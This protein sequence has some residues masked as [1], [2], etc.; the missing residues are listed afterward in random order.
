MNDSTKYTSL[1]AVL[2]VVASALTI[3]K[4]LNAEPLLSANDRSRWATV[5][6]IVERQTYTIDEI[7]QRTGWSTIDKVRFQGHYYSSKP[8]LFPRLVAE[9]AAAVKMAT[10]LSLDDKPRTTSRVVLL[11]VNVLPTIASWVAV[12]WMLPKFARS[13]WAC[14]FTLSVLCFA[15]LN[16]PFLVTLNNHSVAIWSLTLTLACMTWMTVAGPKGRW[17]A[18]G[19]GGLFA[20]WTCCNELPA[21][22]LGVAT[23]VWF[24]RQGWKQAWFAFVPLALIPLAGFFYTNYQVAGTWKPFYMTYG[25]ETYRYIVDGVPSY[26]LRPAGL[27]TNPDSTPVYFMNCTVG[28]HGILSLTPVFL[29][30]LLVWLGFGRRISGAADEGA[31]DTFLTTEELATAKARPKRP[32][33]VDPASVFTFVRH[34][35]LFL[36]V[37]TIGFFLSKTE[38]YNYGGTSC[39]LRWTLWLT[40]LWTIGMLPVLVSVSKS[41]AGRVFACVLLAASTGSAWYPAANPWQHPWIYEVMLRTGRVKVPPAELAPLDPM[42]SWIQSLP[43]AGTSVRYRVVGPKS[44][45]VTLSVESRSNGR[46]I[47]DWSDADGSNEIVVNERSFNSNDNIDRWLVNSTRDRD[48]T[49][50]QLRGLPLVRPYEP[51]KRAYV[52]TAALEDHQSTW[53]LASRVYDR[54]NSR[55]TRSDIWVAADDE[56]TG[57][58]ADEIPF[59]LVQMLITTTDRSGQILARETWSLAEIRDAAN[60]AP[61][62]D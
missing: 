2:I 57:D 43:A 7:D 17:F 51:G 20:A 41:R 25:T 42:H 44:Y 46:V 54:N 30:T 37:L 4:L 52:K 60:P 48:A 35:G 9:V 27:D 14:L 45:D 8:P 47:L 59:G 1:A 3:A 38:N 34:V 49:I 10:G 21:A 62:V 50:A 39:A 29:F 24:W 12:A 53:R 56:I 13:T 6:S 36:T 32:A 28:H 61:A 33:T 55:G 31:S 18:A 22:P 16:S 15:T 23:F 40:P 26:W 58:L 19:L 5:W 11:F